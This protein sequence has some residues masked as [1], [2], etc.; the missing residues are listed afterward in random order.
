MSNIKQEFVLKYTTVGK[1][2]F[3]RFLLS[4]AIF[5]M[6]IQLETPEA[7]ADKYPDH[8]LM[9]LY[10]KFI[11]FYR[12]ENESVYLEIAILCRRAAHKVYRALLKQKIVEK[13]NRYLNL[14]E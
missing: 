3:Y 9:D 7:K 5:E 8:K 11:L 14:V 6:V 12:R 2:K 4:S 10:E 13:N 1:E